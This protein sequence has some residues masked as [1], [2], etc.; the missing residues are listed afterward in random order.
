MDS[1]DYVQMRRESRRREGL[2]EEPYPEH[3]IGSFEKFTKVILMA[4]P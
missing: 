1:R 4:F 2:K 3:H